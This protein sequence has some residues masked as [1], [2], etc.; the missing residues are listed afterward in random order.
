[1]PDNEITDFVLERVFAAPLETVWRAWTDP[2]LFA[3]WYKPN[4]SCQTAVLQHDL[5][6]GG[7]MRY[8]MRFE[9][10]PPHLERWEFE[11]IDPP[12]RLQWRQ[13]LTDADGKIVGNPQMPDWPRVMLTTIDLESHP[14]GALQRLTWRPFEATEA[15][16]TCFQ[17]ASAHLDKGWV[18][19]FNNLGTLLEELASQS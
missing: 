19:G 1:M 9:G 2:E 3:R 5:R 11:S 18:G 12:R 16:V 14:D 10:M 13:M 4:P 17:N 8:E 15:E 7:V 6:P